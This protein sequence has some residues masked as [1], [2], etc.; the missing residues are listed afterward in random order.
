MM[1]SLH[2]ATILWGYSGWLARLALSVSEGTLSREGIPALTL[3]LSG[4]SQNDHDTLVYPV[5][6]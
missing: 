1:F 3:G 4:L 5:F 2:T 6:A